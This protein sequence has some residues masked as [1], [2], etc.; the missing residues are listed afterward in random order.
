MITLPLD[1]VEECA[2]VLD[3]EIAK[4]DELGLTFA[5][6]LVR[7]AHLDLQMQIHGVTEE[8]IDVLSFAEHALEKERQTRKR[9]QDT[10]QDDV[11]PG[12]QKDG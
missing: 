8:E 3:H 10:T 4:L 12:A 7:I 9:Q 11:T 6:S 2:H 5:A 1:K